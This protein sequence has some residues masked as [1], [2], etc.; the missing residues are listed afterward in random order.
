MSD[1]NT[2]G[3]VN[4]PLITFPRAVFLKN[5]LCV[6]VASALGLLRILMS[7]ISYDGRIE[8]GKTS[9]W[10]KGRERRHKNIYDLRLIIYGNSMYTPT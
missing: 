8:I 1:A 4:I 2:D 7:T 5:F 6:T 3:L 9:R 10:R